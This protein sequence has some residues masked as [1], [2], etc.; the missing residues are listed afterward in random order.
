MSADVA[1]FICAVVVAVLVIAWIAYCMFVKER[2]KSE[3]YQYNICDLQRRN[4]VLSE[5]CD[6]TTEKT[7]KEITAGIFILP[8]L[9]KNKDDDY[10]KRPDYPESSASR[11]KV[12]GTDNLIEIFDESS[13]GADAQHKHDIYEVD[14]RFPNDSEV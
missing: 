14:G 9:H 3:F 10:K 6:D 2:P 8:S 7:S 1:G 11:L 4:Q 5:P 12:Q 13:S